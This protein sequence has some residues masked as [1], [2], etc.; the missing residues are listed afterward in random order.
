MNRQGKAQSKRYKKGQGTPRAFTLVEV[1]I[2]VAILGILAAVI[3]PEYRGHTQRAKESSAK[4]SLQMLR[5]AIERYAIQHNGVPPGYPSADPSLTPNYLQYGFQLVR[6]GHYLSELPEN[7]F[8]G[9]VNV[10]VILD[11][12][13]FPAE[14]TGAYGWVY[15]PAT[16]DIRLD[17]PGTDPSGKVYFEY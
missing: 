14:A 8:N 2:V 1:L 16:K 4:E 6:D 11:D 10:R 3:V 17:W 15:K 7:P 13:P 9:H 12:E 5:S